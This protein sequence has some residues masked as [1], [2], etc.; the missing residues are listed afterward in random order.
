M[1]LLGQAEQVRRVG[2]LRLHLLLAVAVVVVGDDGHDDAAFVAGADLEG[3]AAVVAVVLALPAH[4]VALLAV[5]GLVDVG[6]AQRLLRDVDEVRREDDGAG[7]ARPGLGVEGGVVL[8]QVGVAGIAEDA[9]DEVEVADQT[10]GDD[11]T[12]LH[13]PFAGESRDGGHDQGAHQ[14]RDEAGGRGGL[15]GGE[16]QPHVLLGRLEGQL[17]EASED[18]ARDLDLVVRDGQAAGGDV[19]DA[20]GGA[21]VIGG[22]VQ[23]AV[24]QPV[25]AEELGAEL[26]G[27][28]RQA[29][30]TGEAGLVEDQ[31]AVRELGVGVGSG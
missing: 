9:L 20:G 5:G 4:A 29:Q 11:E 25:G 28:D 24:D 10:T 13:G 7:G 22:V 1:L 26:V 6:Q 19:E 2:D 3:L 15:V 16:G 12:G 8:G 27:V 14:Q 23:H 18:L 21:A 17:D 31:G 30:R